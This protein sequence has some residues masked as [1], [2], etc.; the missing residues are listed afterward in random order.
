[1]K[2]SAMANLKHTTLIRLETE[3]GEKNTVSV[4]AVYSKNEEEDSNCVI[5]DD[6]SV[7]GKLR[8]GA[9]TA[10]I[11]YLQKI[12]GE[13][14]IGLSHGGMIDESHVLKFWDRCYA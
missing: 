3:N 2:V 11:R 13:K 14:N 8:Q 9:G 7:L 1:M 5:I 10:A 4:L 6:F 12:L